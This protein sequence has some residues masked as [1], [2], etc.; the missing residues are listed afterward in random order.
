MSDK[1]KIGPA[2]I[3]FQTIIGRQSILMLDATD[4]MQ[5]LHHFTSAGC[6]I[7]AIPE[8]SEL[9]EVSFEEA[10]DLMFPSPIPRNNP[11][12]SQD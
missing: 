10:A 12:R 3:V 2:L 9:K 6:R 8:V 5:D 7:F 1:P 11:H 4:D